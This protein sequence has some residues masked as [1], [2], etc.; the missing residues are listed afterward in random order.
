MQPFSILV[1]GGAEVGIGAT[2]SEVVSEESES[3]GNE[4]DVS[5]MNGGENWLLEDGQTSAEA[6]ISGEKEDGLEGAIHNDHNQLGQDSNGSDKDE[7]SDEEAALAR[8][9]EILSPR[10]VQL[11][12]EI[13]LPKPCSAGR[14][15]EG[16]SHSVFGLGFVGAENGD[17]SCGCHYASMIATLVIECWIRFACCSI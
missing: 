9:F 15:P 5:S 4:E 2:N 7:E 6:A 10:V 12:A 13:G 8:R 16:A 1:A 11:C 3:S 17:I 14:L